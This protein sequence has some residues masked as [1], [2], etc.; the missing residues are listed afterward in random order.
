MYCLKCRRVIQTE[1]ITTS[2]SKI[3]ILTRRG[4]YITCGKT[5]TQFVKRLAGVGNFLIIFVNKL[6]F[7]MYLPG[8]NFTD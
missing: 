8:H 6:P 1:N 3:D 2:T 5:K 4:Q 7:G